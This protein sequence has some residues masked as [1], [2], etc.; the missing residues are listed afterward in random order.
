[1]EKPIEDAILD[2]AQ[3]AHRTS[4]EILALMQETGEEDPIR[5]IFTMLTNITLRQNLMLEKIEAMERKL[6]ELTRQRDAS[7]G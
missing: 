4:Q 3:G 6:I 2:E 1:M 7:H 5:A